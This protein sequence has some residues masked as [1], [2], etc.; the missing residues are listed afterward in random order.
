M[1]GQS[2]LL[3]KLNESIEPTEESQGHNNIMV[4]LGISNNSTC[5]ICG[6][7]EFSIL[8]L[9]LCS[10]AIRIWNTALNP[11]GISF[12]ANGMSNQSIADLIQV[13]NDRGLELVKSA[14]FKLLN[15]I[16]RSSNMDRV[17]VLNN[18]SY[19]VCINLKASRNKNRSDVNLINRLEGI[20]SN[21]S[22]PLQ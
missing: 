19:W 22:S 11:I 21:L 1:V 16:D 8:Q 2:I 13:S 14:I 6:E 18:I 7:T 5:T 9:F 4:K 10:N 17:S 20:M 3:S 12:P 15:Q